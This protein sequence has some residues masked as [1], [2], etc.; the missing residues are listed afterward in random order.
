MKYPKISELLVLE[1][2]AGYYIGRVYKYSEEEYNPYSRDSNY[3]KDKESAQT[4]LI[5]KTYIENF[6]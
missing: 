4:A 5:N 2:A 1:S 6:N 3:F